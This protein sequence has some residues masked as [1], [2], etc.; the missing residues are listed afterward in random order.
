MKVLFYSKK[1]EYSNKILLYLDKNNL[2][3]YFKLVDIDI[4]IIPSNIK[5][6]PTIID[7]NVNNILEGKLAFE[8]LTNIKYFDIKTNNIEE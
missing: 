5:I 2:L 6:V 8:Y 1:C 3:E 4:T 7:T